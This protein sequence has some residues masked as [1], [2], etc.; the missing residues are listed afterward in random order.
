M[1]FVH[2]LSMY[3]LAGT[4]AVGVP[5]AET[6]SQPPSRLSD[7]GGT[8]AGYRGALGTEVKWKWQ[9]YLLRQV[10]TARSCEWAGCQAGSLTGTLLLK[11]FSD[12]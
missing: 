6:L 4:G 7:S 12:A 2:Q 5:G 3:Q 11:R 8:A 10:G 9:H 1:Q